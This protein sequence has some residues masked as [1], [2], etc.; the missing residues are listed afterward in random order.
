MTSIKLFCGFKKNIKLAKNVLEISMDK[1]FDPSEP[2]I[3]KNMGIPIYKENEKKGDL[4]INFNII[5]PKNDN[6][7]INKYMDVFKEIFKKM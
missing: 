4:I 5:Y 7:I 3:Y 6:K 2:I 1:Y